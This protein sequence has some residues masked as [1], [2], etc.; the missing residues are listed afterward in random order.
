MTKNIISK[1]HFLL[2]SRITEEQNLMTAWRSGLRQ[3]STVFPQAYMHYS[4]KFISQKKPTIKLGLSYS[5][6]NSYGNSFIIISHRKAAIMICLASIDFS[7]SLSVS[8]LPPFRL[9]FSLFSLWKSVAYLI[10]CQELCPCLPLSQV[11]C[12]E[13][14][15]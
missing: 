3:M 7:L 5:Y 11:L 1:K 10:T 14:R 15:N 12:A 8:S 2:V 6:V 4:S 13:C 9:W